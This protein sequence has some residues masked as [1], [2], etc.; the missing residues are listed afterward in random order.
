MACLSVDFAF[1][2]PGPVDP[3]FS[4]RAFAVRSVFNNFELSSN[5][6]STTPCNHRD[7]DSED[8][9]SV[10]MDGRIVD[11]KDCGALDMMDS[12]IKTEFFSS[13]PDEFGSLNL[14]LCEFILRFFDISDWINFNFSFS[15]LE[16]L[17]DEESISVGETGRGFG[18]AAEDSIWRSFCFCLK[19]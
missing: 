8:I 12:D 19:E 6:I 2:I 14:S 3:L 13:D 7:D 9:E 1:S 10:L 18:I 4:Q 11:N 15:I 5:G 17:A 16:I